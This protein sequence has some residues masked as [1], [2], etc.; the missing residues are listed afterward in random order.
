MGVFLA[1]TVAGCGR[2]A[3]ADRVVVIEASGCGDAFDSRVGG[4]VVADEKVVT[5]AHGLAQ[6]EDIVVD[7]GGRTFHGEVVGYDARTDLALVA[8]MGL[9]AFDVEFGR[10]ASGDVVTL[11][12][13]LVSGDVEATVDQVM[14][15]RIE[16]VLGTERVERAGLELRVAAE[17]GDSG[18]GLFDT[19]GRLAG[20][21][22]AVNDDGAEVGWA[23]AAGEV[24][25]LLSGPT[26]VWDCD[27]ARSKLVRVDH[28]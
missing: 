27:P 6:A 23:T 20:V 26:E 9:D 21:L 19:E 14:T 3:P 7:W 11:V 5:V 15:I 12:G 22:F 28:G 1:M 24:S 17:I 13:G 10:P 8:V 4:V 2:G 16:E 25:A 18:A